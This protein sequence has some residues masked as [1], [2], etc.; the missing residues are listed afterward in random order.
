MLDGFF[1]GKGQN[2]RKAFESLMDFSALK[3]E[4]AAEPHPPLVGQNGSFLQVLPMIRGTKCVNVANT[5]AF[6]GICGLKC[7]FFPIPW[8]G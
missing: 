3:S 4:T 8:V 7:R 1:G 5:G 6:L 2:G